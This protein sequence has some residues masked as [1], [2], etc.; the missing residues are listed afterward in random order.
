[1]LNKGVQL[2]SDVVG[3][4]LIAVIWLY[5]KAISPL[6]GQRCRFEPTCS[7][8]AME[9]IRTHGPIVGFW[10]ALRR[11]FRCHPWGGQGFDPVPP[12][13]KQE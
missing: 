8:Y 10:L 1:M 7:V 13:K 11:L 6:L 5:K 4:L 9:A 2:L 12:R 3:R